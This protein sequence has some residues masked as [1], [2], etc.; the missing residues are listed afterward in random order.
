LFNAV[1]YNL[2]HPDEYDA[3]S[4]RHQAIYYMLKHH[5]LIQKHPDYE[6]T[7]DPKETMNEYIKNTYNLKIYGDRLALVTIAMCWNITITILYC[8]GELDK[9]GHT[10]ELE[11]TDVVIIYNKQNHY[12]GTGAYF[13]SIL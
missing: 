3:I 5:R 8:T 1:L 13:L 4:L 7:R 2:D 9:L 11:D 12:T 10:K 6:N